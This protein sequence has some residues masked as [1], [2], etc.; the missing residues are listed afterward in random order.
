MG[1][2]FVRCQFHKGVL[3]GSLRDLYQKNVAKLREPYTS[4]DYIGEQGVVKLFCVKMK[5]CSIAGWVQAPLR[6]AVL[7]I[8]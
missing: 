8:P 2:A 3:T 7:Y 4:F 1:T 6:E 5:V